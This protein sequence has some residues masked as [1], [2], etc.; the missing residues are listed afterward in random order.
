MECVDERG[1]QLARDYDVI[2]KL[3]SFRDRIIRLVC[4]T[5]WHWPILADTDRHRLRHMLQSLM[6]YCI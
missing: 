5:G 6:Q 2:N 4:D 3:A 1:N